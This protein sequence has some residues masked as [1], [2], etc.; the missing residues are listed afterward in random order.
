MDHPRLVR[1]FERLGDLLGDRE[2]LI[3]WDRPLGDPVGE[4]RPLD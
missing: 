1:G 4:R 3:Q 2:R